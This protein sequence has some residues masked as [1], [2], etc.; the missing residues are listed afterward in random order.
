M[1]TATSAP[2]RPATGLRMH[3]AAGL[4]TELAPDGRG[5]ARTRIAGMRSEAPLKLRTTIAAA[6]EPW[7]AHADDFARV[8]LAASAAGPIGGDRLRLDIVVGA[9][10]SLVLTEASAT[11]LLPGHDGAQSLLEVNVSVESGATFVWLPQPV[12]AVRGCHHVNAVTV[13]LAQ[14]ARVL[15]REE[16]V[17]GRKDEPS[18]RLRQRTRVRRAGVPIHAQDLDLG[19]D[20][21]PAVTGRHG[22]VGSLLVVDPD[23]TQVGAGFL[24]EDGVLLPLAAPGAVLANALSADSSGLRDQL[25]HAL[26]LLGRPW[27][28]RPVGHDTADHPA[29]AARNETTTQETR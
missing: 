9:G 3:A 5:A 6:P 21:G 4:R 27:D 14:D 11:L 12:I 26:T 8:C 17:L 18:G 24:P 2:G 20:T 22:A 19:G 28:P 1:I 23:P 29:L 25:D 16:L 7:A 10:S 15:L 13:E